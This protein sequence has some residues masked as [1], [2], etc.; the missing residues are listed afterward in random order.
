MKKKKPTKCEDISETFIFIFVQ[1][2]SFIIFVVEEVSVFCQLIFT[3][4]IQ[5]LIYVHIFY[6]VLIFK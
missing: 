2:Y 3:R 5:Q 1:K 4:K 6:H